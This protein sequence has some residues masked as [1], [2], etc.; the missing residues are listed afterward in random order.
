VR[1]FA[2]YL[3]CE[4]AALQK[5]CDRS[6]N[7]PSHGFLNY[8]PTTRYAVLTFQ[9]LQGL[10]STAPGSEGRGE[11]T[12]NE[13]AIWV[14]AVH[15][16]ADGSA[17][18][19]RAVLVPYIF[20]DDG[21]AIATGREVYGYPKEYANVQIPFDERSRDA[22][23]AVKATAVPRFHEG[24][25]AVAK[26]VLRCQR[27]GGALEAAQ[28]IAQ[29]V[30]EDLW[31][32]LRDGKVEDTPLALMRDFIELLLTKQMHLVFL[33]QM[34]ALG[35]G[36]ASDLQAIVGGLYDPVKVKCLRLLKG[37]YE[38]ILPALD[39]HPIADDLGLALT[40]GKADILMGIEVDLGFT[41][42]PGEN[43]WPSRTA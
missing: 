24:A 9:H 22:Y 11:H 30:G 8:R 28:H 10:H 26:E 32:A 39:S 29:G 1:M 38:L 35:G 17:S 5:I 27:A 6:L 36:A 37:R 42:Q 4:L 3:P 7:E 25:K 12:Y 15:R 34:R 40:D 13:A 43:L 41:L 14:M 31:S 20:A 23:F 19:E 21:R 2:F 33:R 16:R 18:D